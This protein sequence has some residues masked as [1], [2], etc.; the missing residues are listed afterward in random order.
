MNTSS[1]TV[2]TGMLGII[3]KVRRRRRLIAAAAL[4]LSAGAYLLALIGAAVVMDWQFAWT[5]PALRWL[6][7]LIAIIIG[8]L[9]LGVL[10]RRLQLR[11][12]L[13]DEAREIDRT[14]PALEERW[15]TVTEL[16]TTKRD[17]VLKGSPELIAK[18][19]TEAS[20]FEPRV[21]PEAIVPSQSLRWPAILC[22]SA[23]VIFGVSAFSVAGHLGT[24]LHRFF[25]P[26]EEVTLTRLE[27]AV[28]PQRVMRQGAHDIKASLSGRLPKSATLSIMD[29]HG[30]VRT[31]ELSPK[32][33]VIGGTVVHNVPEVNEPFSYQIRAGDALSDWIQVQP[34]DR[35][36]LHEF[37]LRLEWP[38]YTKKAA[39]TWSELPANIRALRGSRFAMEFSA[40]Q[41]LTRAELEISQEKKTAPLPLEAIGPQRYRFTAELQEVLHFQIVAENEF[42]LRSSGG[43]CRIEVV[44]DQPPEVKI[45]ETS[46]DVVLNPDETLRIDFQAKDDF[47]VNSAEIV[48]VTR[49]EGEA[50]K[51]T[52]IPIELG[53]ETGGTAMKKSVDLDLKQFNLD[54]KTEISYAVRVRDNRSEA[55]SA[56]PSEEG[57]D[58]KASEASKTAE[59][60]PPPP[61]DPSQSP[62]SASPLAE[63]SG[64]ATP[65]TAA[66]PENPMSKRN[67]DLACQ[68]CTPQKEVRI[69]KY[70]GSY[71]GEARNKKSIAI[72]AVLQ[73]LRKAAKE[74]LAKTE[75]AAEGLHEAASLDTLRAEQVRAGLTHTEEGKRLAGNLKK[76]SEGT[77]Y[78]F[79]AIQTDGLVNG[80]LDPAAAKLRDALAGKPAKQNLDGAAVSLRWVIA[81]LDELTRQY[82]SL[83]EVQ[84][85]Q[86][87]LQQIK[88]MHLVFLEDMP[89]WLKAGA[90]GSPYERQMLEVDAAFAKAYEEFLK[91][92][93][94]VYKQL[95]ELLAKHPELQARFLEA[96]KTS[97]TL[98]RDELMRLKGEQDALQALTKATETA[99]KNEQAAT[100]WQARIEKLRANVA[101][102]AAQ[103][104]KSTV[105]WMPADFSPELQASLE[106]G[107]GE[108]SKAALRA[109][110]ANAGDEEMTRAIEQV[111]NFEDAIAK[112]GAANSRN[113]AYARNRFEDIDKLRETLEQTRRF[114]KFAE[115]RKFPDA[116]HAAQ[117]V[118]NS[119]TLSAAT[120][121]QQ[122]A[123]NLIGLGNEVH[124][125][126]K[127][128]D[129]VLK[130]GVTTPQGHAIEAL[131][132]QSFQPAIQS[133]GLAAA[134]LE[135][136]VEALDDFIQKAIR[137]MD[138]ANAKRGVS[139]PGAP[140]SLEALL[141]SLEEE[142]RSAMS[143]GISCQPMNIQ[144]QNDWQQP[145]KGQGQAAGAAMQQKRA[146]EARINAEAAAREAAK[147]QEQANQRAKAMAQR[148]ETALV[149][150]TAPGTAKRGSDKK[151]DWNTVPSELRASLLQER[152]QAPPKRYEN[153]IRQYFKSIAETPAASERPAP[154]NSAPAQ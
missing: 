102:Q 50:P 41:P 27:T 154:V 152:G 76:E 94:D 28:S 33:E 134:G 9:S 64:E 106:T 4:G 22:V 58:S 5:S 70:S 42:G 15:S 43:E 12:P 128:F 151:D 44:E 60:S 124:E 48:A 88:E 133:Q 145:G 113:S 112:S 96:S 79:F 68:S 3:T 63:K 122:E 17:P 71:D 150:E 87:L 61:S 81:T 82:S 1:S 105:T 53:K 111:D 147:A 19:V 138:E 139:A 73:G 125:A 84:K 92:R 80:G 98:F 93:R 103:F 23:A 65:P 153:A 100:L 146:E 116:L 144:V 52:V 136:S 131:K 120:M 26:W 130:E 47:G 59:N 135:R 20:A 46:Q 148:L 11:R 24:L 37:A 49:K 95:A 29:R 13:R 129:D 55:M 86:D 25:A 83:K 101:G 39:T 89:K 85:A 6:P 62:P 75:G 56:S 99:E 35:P 69:E 7:P 141:K 21:D 123:V 121:I 36:Q 110:A 72:D 38:A 78:A 54:E 18:V 108:V 45:L 126:V 34:V 115:D 119:E 107:A 14:I 117:A 66:P 77:P 90:V 30:A 57:E 127:R 132:A 74:A 31:V 143:L 51:E 104:A 114:A 8:A 109:A 40:D 118:V 32:K 97:A 67:L 137:R 149:S 91:K 140:P 142:K 2:P 10:T 16:S